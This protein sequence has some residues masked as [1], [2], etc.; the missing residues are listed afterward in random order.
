[1]KKKL[2]FVDQAKTIIFAAQ[3]KLNCYQLISQEEWD[4]IEDISIEQV[5]DQEVDSIELEYNSQNISLNTYLFNCIRNRREFPMFMCHLD[6]KTKNWSINSPVDIRQEFKKIEFEV[7][8][9][10]HPE[11]KR[12]GVKAGM[13][14]HGEHES[15]NGIEKDSIWFKAPSGE[16]CVIYIQSVK[17][18]PEEN[19]VL[20]TQNNTK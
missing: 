17:V 8:D 1:M 16:T 12:E 11:L 10:V 13:I 6:S 5:N 7:K 4:F 20:S 14:F 9:P 18:I 19:L 3:S 15:I 2:Y